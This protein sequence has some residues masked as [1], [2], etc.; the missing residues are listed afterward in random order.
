MGVPMKRERWVFRINFGFSD[1]VKKLD[2]FYKSKWCTLKFSWLF[3]KP[4][5]MPYTGKHQAGDKP[6]AHGNF[7]LL[8]AK[9]TLAIPINLRTLED[10]HEHYRRVTQCGQ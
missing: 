9:M 8:V 6:C 7:C 10:Q 5:I 3:S 4:F 2:A 1:W